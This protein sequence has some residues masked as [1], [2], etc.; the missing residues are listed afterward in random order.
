MMKVLVTGHL[1]YI[2]VHL[3]DVL[4]SAG[5]S[6]TGCDLG[7]FAGCEW[8]PF[9]RPDRELIKD[10]GELTERDIDGHD[11]ICHL[12]A[13][14]NDPMGD[15]D[16]EVTLSINR[17]HS[18]ELARKAKRSGIDRFLFS[19][20]CSVYGGG[21]KMDLEETDALNPLTAYARSKIEAEEH[22]SDLAD[23]N[24]TPV[25]LRNATAYG[26]SPMLRIDL[27]VNNLLGSALSYG[28]IRIM[29]DGSPWRPLIHCRDIAHAFVAF[30]EADKKT[31]HNQA[32]NIGGIGENYQVRDIGNLVKELIPTAAVTYTG[33]VGA[34]PRNYRVRFDKLSRL[35]PDFKLEYDLKRGMVEL[36][37]KMVEHGFGKDD[38]EGDKFVRLRTLRNRR[39]LLTVGPT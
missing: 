22:I 33:E 35:L 18:V 7:L 30:L 38:F 19:G 23:D 39:P 3:V 34:D 31:I 37:R 32:V 13:I 24:F 15:L 1:G 6:V 29:S 27:V 8:E 9:V 20:S 10:V 12:A 17:D 36:H 26:H 16:P 21:E 11:A 28:E 14:S 5:H 2:G 25:Y 4:K